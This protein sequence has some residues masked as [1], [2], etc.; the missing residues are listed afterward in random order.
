MYRIKLGIDGKRY[1]V[2]HSCYE[3]DL[4][5]WAFPNCCRACFGQYDNAFQLI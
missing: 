2:F 4:M 5:E 3:A 1:A